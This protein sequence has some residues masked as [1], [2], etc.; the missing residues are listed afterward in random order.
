MRLKEQK[1]LIKNA[2][3][4]EKDYTRDE[5]YYMRVQLREV[6][7]Q[8]ALK[9]WRRWQSKVGFGNSDTM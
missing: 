5:V 4:H 1:Q 2:L 7:R 9:K 6:K 8:L 3:K